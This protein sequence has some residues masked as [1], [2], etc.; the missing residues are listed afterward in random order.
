MVEA[1]GVCMA[2]LIVQILVTLVAR[3]R[4]AWRDALRIG[5][6]MMF[7]FTAAAHFASMKTQLAA[8]IPPPLT[9]AL[10]VIYVTGVLEAAGAAGLLLKRTRRLAGIGLALLLIGMFPANVYAALAGVPLRGAAA[11]ALWWRAPLQMFWLAVLWWS[12][13][14][15]PPSVRAGSS[16]AEPVVP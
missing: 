10:W 5:I 11:S 8:M 7:F 3:I 12:A 2:P 16:A 9:G 15:V 1:K 14:T 13:I 4:F 6:A